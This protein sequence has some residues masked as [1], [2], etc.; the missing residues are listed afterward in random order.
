MISGAHQAICTFGLSFIVRS[1]WAPN[2]NHY[3]AAIF[4][5]GTLVSSAMALVLAV[6]IGVAIGIYLALLAGPGSAP[7]SGRWSSCWRR[8]PA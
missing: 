1:T 2:F 4:I 5:Y 8:C 6:P 3:S 7:W